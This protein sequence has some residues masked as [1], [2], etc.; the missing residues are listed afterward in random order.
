MKG[1]R[2]I[3]KFPDLVSNL[4]RITLIQDIVYLVKYENL[5]AE[6]LVLKKRALFIDCTLFSCLLV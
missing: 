6:Q 5:N 1:F 4:V 3:E 2:G